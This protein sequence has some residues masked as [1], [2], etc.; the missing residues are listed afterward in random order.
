MRFFRRGAL[1][2][3]VFMLAVLQVATGALAQDAATPSASTPVAIGDD[4]I[5]RLG[6]SL[7]SVTAAYGAPD[8]TADGLVRYD[9]AELNGIPTILV[10]YYDANQTVTRLALVYAT[11]PAQLADTIGI[12]TAAGTVAPADGTCDATSISTDFGTQVYPCHSEALASVFTAEQMTALGVTQGEPGDYSV[13]VDPLPD[14]YFELIVQLGTDGASLA[15]T[16]VPGEP[17]PTPTPT[18]AE[19]YPEL[20]DPT[21]LMDG[22]VPLSEP[23]SFTGDILTLQVAEFGKQ[24]RLGQDQSLGVS[25]LFQVEVPVKNSTDTAVLFVGYNGDATTLAI[26]D[27]VTVY[28]TD[29]GTQCFDNAMKKEVCQPLIAADMVEQHAS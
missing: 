21:A 15:P 23:L 12:M 3:V 25:S 24:F 11:R 1:L 4:L 17:T 5:A 26:G 9:D 6:G 28:G 13:A 19:Q 16:P 10:V 7:D 20:D 22:D 18:L 8:F 2:A 29:F 14:A 27:S